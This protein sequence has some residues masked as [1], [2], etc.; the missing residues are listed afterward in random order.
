M[1]SRAFF[2]VLLVIG[3]LSNV[4]GW[5][6]W[7]HQRI[8]RLAVFT[9]PPEMLVVYKAHLEYLTDHAVDPDK[10]RYAVDG[11]AARHYIDVDHWGE[12]PFPDL[13]RGWKEAVEKYSE[14]SLMAFGILPYQLPWRLFQLKEAFEQKDL[15]A[16]LKISADLGHYV[17][18]GHVP[19]H[20]TE[21]YNGQMTGQR[22]IHGF[23]ESRL[24]ELFAGDYDFFVGRAYYIDNLGEESWA[25]V[26][27]SHVL[28][29]SVLGFERELSRSFPADRKYGYES[30]NNVV[31]R[32]YSRE[33]SD[34]Y[35]KRLNGMV[36]RRMRQSIRAVGAWWYT[37]WKMAGS[38]DLR[39]L[40]GQSVEDAPVRFEEHLKIIDREAIDL[41]LGWLKKPLDL[42]CT[43]SPKMEARAFGMFHSPIH[44]KKTATPWWKWLAGKLIR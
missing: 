19:L 27:S 25:T 34:A 38:P 33:Y 29:D 3:H 42:C 12:Y 39:E 44:N 20:T 14:D 8:N 16:I 10:R 24:P 30:R 9:L 4:H 21:N 23:W 40:V 2:L 6:F 31:V 1:K 37:A 41:G 17:G 5:G 36:E 7:A 32:T 13:P 18:D 28:L 26:L 35:H 22:G 11:E 43:P 15:A